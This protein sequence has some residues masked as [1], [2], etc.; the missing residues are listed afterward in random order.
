MELQSES[1]GHCVRHESFHLRNKMSVSFPRCSESESALSFA[2]RLQLC[3]VALSIQSGFKCLIHLRQ[4]TVTPAIGPRTPA[5]FY[6]HRSLQSPNRAR[7]MV[8][9][10]GG[11]QIFT[12]Y[13][14]YCF[15]NRDLISE[16]WNGKL[17]CVYSM[18]AYTC[19]FVCST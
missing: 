13:T 2:V 15:C 12:V 3:D 17:L 18:C 1:C 11:G 6:V 9:I 16:H 10:S 19:M 4:H 14:V 7:F 8:I 5:R